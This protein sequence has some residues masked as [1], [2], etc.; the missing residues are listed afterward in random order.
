MP[1]QPKMLIADDNRSIRLMLETGVI[2][3]AFGDSCTR[4]CRVSSFISNWYY[5]LSNL[6]MELPRLGNRRT[7]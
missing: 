4:P 2:R 6:G 3:N 5:R 7:P 1:Y